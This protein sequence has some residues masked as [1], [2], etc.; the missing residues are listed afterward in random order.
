MPN[1]IVTR[2][3]DAVATSEQ[4][5]AIRE[6]IPAEWLPAASG[7]PEQCARRIADQFAAGADGVIL[8]ASLPHEVAPVLEAW[9][10][11]RPSARFEGRSA[12]PA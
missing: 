6:L 4:L 9:A 8:H 5:R 10:R 2:A 7:S 1:E 11:I 12:R 3:I